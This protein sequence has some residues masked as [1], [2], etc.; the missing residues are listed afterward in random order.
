[1]R[2]VDFS[3]TPGIRSS[4]SLSARLTS[5]GNWIPGGSAPSCTWGPTADPG[6]DAARPAVRPP[7]SRKTAAASRFDKGDAPA[8]GGRLIPGKQ[9]AAAHRYIR[10]VKNP[11]EPVFFIKRIAQAHNL[12]VAVRRG[13][14]DHL[15][16]LPS[17]DEGGGVAVDGQLL[18]VLDDSVR[19]EAMGRRM[20]S[21]FLLGASS[22][23][24][25]SLGSSMLTLIRSTEFPAFPPARESSRGWPWREY[26]R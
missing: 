10:G 19:M 1:M 8:A 22:F 3:P 14:H 24:L 16:G 2:W 25:F 18:L 6:K 21:F 13:A 7:G 4:S 17:G 20:A 23:R 5:T 15:R 11:L 12:P 26:S 9:G